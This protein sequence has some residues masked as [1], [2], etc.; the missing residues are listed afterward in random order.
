MASRD[1]LLDRIRELELRRERVVERAEMHGH[2]RDTLREHREIKRE[3][4]AAQFEISKLRT[5]DWQNDPA[6]FCRAFKRTAKRMLDDDVYAS[7]VN[8]TVQRLKQHHA[9]WT[10]KQRDQTNE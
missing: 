4:R 5:K 10:K 3:L 2:D 8:Q 9:Q 1:E 6:H 7:I